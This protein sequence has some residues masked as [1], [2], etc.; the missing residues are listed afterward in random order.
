MGA[1][2]L[3]APSSNLPSGPKLPVLAP[4]SGV[5]G[6]CQGQPPDRELDRARLNFTLLVNYQTSASQV[7]Y[8]F[9]SC[10]IVGV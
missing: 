6:R 1:A 10:L 7:L 3:R 5:W 2:F 4:T 9:I 8:G